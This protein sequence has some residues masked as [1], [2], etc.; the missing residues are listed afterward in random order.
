L[1][2]LTGGDDVAQYDDALFAHA[3]VAPF[4]DVFCFHVEQMLA[5]PSS[6]ARFPFY[7]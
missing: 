4:A 1:T 3:F 6:Y 5:V 2:G 7:F